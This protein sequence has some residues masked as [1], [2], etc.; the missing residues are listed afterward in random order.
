M[1]KKLTN[2]EYLKMVKNI[3]GDKEIDYSITIYINRRT[4]IRFICHIHGEVEQLPYTHLHG[5]GCPLCS[6][7][8]YKNNFISKS[9]IIHGYRYDYSL[10]DYVNA[11]KKVKIICTEHGVFEQR[12]N[13]HLSGYGCIKCSNRNN[14]KDDCIMNFNK[15]HNN[16]YDY[17]LI[18]YKN[19]KTKIK[20]ICKEHGI[21]EQRPDN[22]LNNGCPFCNESNGEKLIKTILNRKKIKY[23]YQKKF[24]DCKYI[25]TLSFDYYLPNKNICIEYDGKQHYESISFFGGDDTLKK[26][27]ER[28]QI[29]NEYC[30]NNNIH[31]LRIKYNEN[32]EEKLNEF[33][34]ITTINT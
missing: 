31:L 27:Q 30:K 4:K 15:I 13:D 17:S 22:H 10:V 34:K 3:H 1:P 21:F 33:L 18:D 16:K 8:K 11:H 25:K 19:N 12:P 5:D 9:I 29:K 28:D 6:K 32:I 2:D 24:K 20:I 7:D 26:Q 23:E 14:K